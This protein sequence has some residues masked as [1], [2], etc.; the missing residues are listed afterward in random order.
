MVPQ[1]NIRGFFRDYRMSGSIAWF[2]FE[3]CKV[4]TRAYCKVYKHSI[5]PHLLACVGS[6]LNPP[7]LAPPPPMGWAAIVRYL[8][9]IWGGGGGGGEWRDSSVFF[10]ERSALG[11]SKTRGWGYTPQSELFFIAST[12][13]QVKRSLYFL[14]PIAKKFVQK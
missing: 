10:S 6:F 7:T 11:R 12:K 14:F 13:N 2:A 5:V 4:P 3:H 8:W 9:L 1:G